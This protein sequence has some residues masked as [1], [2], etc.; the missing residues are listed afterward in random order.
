MK[1]VLYGIVG[2]TA[3]GKT[4]IGIGVAKQVD[5]EIISV[6]SVQVY[7]GMDIGSAKPPQDE[8]AGVRHHMLDCTDIET[9]V[10]SVAEFRDRAFSIIDDLFMHAKQPLLVG[11]SSLYIDALTE[12]LGFAVPGSAAVRKRCEERYN[13]SPDETWSF[14]N[15]VD[16]ITAERLHIHDKK[17]I[18]RALEVYVCSGRTLSEFGSDYANL[19]ETS[20]RYPSRLFG[21]SLERETLYRRIDERVEQ[22]ITAGLVQEAMRIYEHIKDRS[23]PAMQS[24]G[25]KQLFWYFDGLCT[26]N[27]AIANIKKAT[28][29][30]AKRQMTWLRRKSNITWFE[31]GN[32]DKDTIAKEISQIIKE[33]RDECIR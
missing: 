30:F 20:P 16:S 24:I 13:Q 6:D 31:L 28:R 10:F 29:H 9:S 3:C 18:V 22:M 19:R 15:S 2:P 11:G 25:Y 17:R 33:E 21:L 7:R 4:E 12:P 23:L 26:L 27:E 8:R 5:A 14:L 1:Q 32:M